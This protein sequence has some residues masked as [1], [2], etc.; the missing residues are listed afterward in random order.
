VDEF[1]CVVTPQGLA[2]RAQRFGGD[3]TKLE[4]EDRPAVGSDYWST[5]ATCVPGDRL[6]SVDSSPIATVDRTSL[7]TFGF[8]AVVAL[9]LIFLLLGVL[10]WAGRHRMTRAQRS[11]REWPT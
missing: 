1:H 3:V 11:A 9:V 2:N 5:S 6:V 4:P 8:V 10:A 7:L